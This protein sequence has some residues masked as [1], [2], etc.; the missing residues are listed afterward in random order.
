MKFTPP[1]GTVI[2]GITEGEDQRRIF[3]RDTGIGI[4]PDQV[5]LM[6]EPFAQADHGL[7]RTK[8]GLGLGLALVKGFVNLHGG[9]VRGRS[10]GIGKGAEFV[11]V[12]PLA[13]PP[14]VGSAA[15]AT[16]AEAG[17]RLIL[18]IEDNVDAGQTLADI[19]ELNGHRVRVARDGRSGLALARELRPDVVLC[20]IGLPDLDGYEVARALHADEALRS[21]RLVALSG[22]A[23]EEDR[24]RAKE[25]GF[26]AHIPKPPALDVLLAV[27]AAKG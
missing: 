23:Q 4:E 12:L 20:D 1:H 7:A 19:L 5:E 27:V 2:V 15:P 21:T 22:Y 11:V 17:S 9:S 14:S 10:D 24:R 16:V 8:G 18:V 13:K 6:F 26:D 3:V 25:T